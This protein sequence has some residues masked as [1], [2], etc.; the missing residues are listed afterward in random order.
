M[1]YIPW[2]DR[3]KPATLGER[4]GLN[5]ISTARNTL[6]PTKS[7]AQKPP[8]NW[9][10]GNWWDPNDQSVGG[11]QILED[12][13]HTTATMHKDGGRIDMKPG[14]LVEPGV[15]HYAT[16]HKKIEKGIYQRPNGNYRITARR[17]GKSFDRTF[18]K[19]TK[20]EDIRKVLNR[21]Y[22]NNPIEVE[23]KEGQKIKLISRGGKG[24]QVIIDVVYKTPEIEKA[25]KNALID[26]ASDNK[27]NWN[28][29]K[30]NEKFGN[31]SQDA[32]AFVRKQD[33][34][35]I[36]N[37]N[38]IYTSKYAK[39]LEEAGFKDWEA[40]RA[41]GQ[42]KN[43]T[44]K[45]Y[46]TLSPKEKKGPVPSKQKLA[47]NL[48]HLKKFEKSGQTLEDFYEI[49]KSQSFKQNLRA[50]LKGEAGPLVTQAWD[51]AGFKNKYKSI[52][53]KLKEHLEVW[54]DY[55]KKPGTAYK[56]QLK[57]AKIKKYSDLHTENMINKAK[58]VKKT[59]YTN[60][61]DK[62]H[63]QELVIDQNISELGVERPEI[64]RVLI[65]D[66]ELERNK[67][68]RKN[69]ELVNEIKKGNNVEKNLRLIN[70]NNARITKIAEL[71]KGR[72][73]GITINPDTLEAVKLKPSNIMGV[74]AGILNKSM[75]DLTV[76][77]KK[78]LRTQILP[79]VIEEARA[80]TPQKIAADL[81]GIMDDPVLSEKLATRMKN[82][83]TGKQ[84][85][86]PVFEKSQEVYKLLQKAR[87]TPKGPGR[88]K[89][90]GV[91][92]AAGATFELLNEHGI[93]SAEAA[94]AQTQEASAVT[95]FSL[96]S[97][98]ELFG[99]ATATTIGTDVAHR[100]ANLKKLDFAKKIPTELVKSGFR[101][102][103][104]MWTPAGDLTFH[105][106]WS[107]EPKLKDFTEA[108]AAAGYDINSDEFKTGWNTLSKQEQKETL[109]AWADKT[110]DKRSTGQK[111]EDTAMSPFTHM[112]YAFWKPGM[113]SMKKALTY[114]GT[115][116]TVAKQLALRAMRM[117]IPMNAIKF[118]NP[119]G[120]HLFL[121]TGVTKAFTDSEPNLFRDEK[122]GDLKMKDEQITPLFSNMI[123]DHDYRFTSD[124]YFK[125]EYD[126]TKDEYKKQKN[127]PEFLDLDKIKEKEKKEDYYTKGEHYARGGIASLLKW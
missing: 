74:D 71:T 52:V 81:K 122:T 120:W 41:A 84:I 47:E 106:L 25:F 42:E 111:I 54:H 82:L 17:A 22:A 61:L 75:K 26:Y 83:K 109:Y 94:E 13:D 107:D 29:A 98:W 24:E 119:I 66:A 113:E 51:E 4:F 76:A 60:L 62:A 1:A 108:L 12:F 115:N 6:S 78:V 99:G 31:I 72:L 59:D 91:L 10:Q 80:M 118:I 103:P 58:R 77:D 64:N 73:T 55:E 28:K 95:D 37:E 96:P 89:I 125:K 87:N 7:Y 69:F 121:A 8:Y 102:L 43:V 48:Q 39:E 15:T 16:D 126:I 3:L 93:S 33:P 45:Y 86:K 49:F 14:G 35:F 50:Y 9:E 114:S 5:E 11:T 27:G 20:L 116:K 85:T 112:G 100:G 104:F 124:E 65:K 79:Q 97:K 30:L 21:W 57:T 105:A 90:I 101:W 110:M 2:Y 40:A 34:T 19:G 70:E 67:L 88:L 46:R 36:R 127:L 44:S 92:L 38:K 68:H 63:R 123:K 117:G 23:W 56:G 32:A 18:S 53:P